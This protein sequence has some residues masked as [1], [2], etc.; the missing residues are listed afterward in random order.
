MSQTIPVPLPPEAAA[1][2]PGV[3]ATAPSSDAVGLRVATL[4]DA[5]AIHALIEA[6][7]T[8]GHL[9]PRRLA[10]IEG[11]H[12]R[13]VVA[14]RGTDVVGAA[15]LAPLSNRVAEVRSLVVRG[16]ARHDG[17]GRRL[18]AELARRGRVDGFDTV[19]AFTHGP[20]FFVRLGFSIV[21]HH[22]VPEKI[23]VDCHACPLFRTCEQ[24]AVVLSLSAHGRAGR[25]VQ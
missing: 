22:W 5:P 12:A 21:P 18:V 7:V 23:Q 9:L 16:D 20:A 1:L 4:G 6:H 15:E 10:D 14:V 19:T 25:P 2:P 24:H 13:F 17:V 8:E 3:V 11:R